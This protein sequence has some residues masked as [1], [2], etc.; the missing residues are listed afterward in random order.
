[1]KRI[2]LTAAMLVLISTGAAAQSQGDWVL[3]NW[4]GGGYWFPGVVQSHVGDKITIAYDD[5][6][7]ETASSTQVRPYTWALGTRIECRWS[8]GKAWF[9]GQIT[10]ISKDGT[11]IDVKYDDGDQERLTTGACR[12]K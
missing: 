6:T 1:M 8:G 9:G 7:R 11:Q 3:G 12:S 4:R 2:M 10:G 5:G